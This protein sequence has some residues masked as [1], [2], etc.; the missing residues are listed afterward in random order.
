MININELQTRLRTA[1]A[2]YW[3]TRD[4][5]GKRQKDQGTSDQGF[6][7]AVTGGAHM[8]GV[9]Q[10]LSEII[11]EFGIPKEC[12]YY[13]QFLQLPGFFGLQRNGIY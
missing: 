2:F 1:I 11:L 13:R 9:I 5:Q 7:S 3:Q 8:N 10:L 4:A 12:I 6:R